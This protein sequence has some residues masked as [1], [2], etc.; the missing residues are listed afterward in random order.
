MMDDTIKVFALFAMVGLAA[1]IGMGFAM[2]VL[3]PRIKITVVAP[4]GYALVRLDDTRA[5]E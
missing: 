4:V 2:Y 1:G 3:P 5:G